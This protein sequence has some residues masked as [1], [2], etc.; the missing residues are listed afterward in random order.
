MKKRI[1]SQEASIKAFLTELSMST[2]IPV[3]RL[4]FTT[5]DGPNEGR[6][7]RSA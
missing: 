6:G 3:D 7:T 2:G 5:M 4:I 1:K